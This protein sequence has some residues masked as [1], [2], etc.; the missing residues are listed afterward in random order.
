MR[1]SHRCPKCTGTDLLHA[2]Q[3]ADHVGEGYAHHDHREPRK[4]A[5][6]GD[7]ATRFRIARVLHEGSYG[8]AG[9][10]EAWVCRG[11]GF[12]E[13]YTVDPDR[14]PV[15]GDLVVAVSGGSSPYR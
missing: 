14:I 8:S 1:S 4:D 5:V 7:G 10:V 11:C 6:D 13:L 3:V 2:R 9:R 12:T 15:D